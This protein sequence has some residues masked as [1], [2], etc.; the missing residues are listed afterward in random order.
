MTATRS[1][2]FVWLFLAAIT[3]ASWWLAP[4]HA[5]GAAQPSVPITVTVVLLGFVKGRM[6]LRYFMEVRS[7]PRWL[8]LATDGWLTA[9]WAAVLAIYLW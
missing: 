6:I 4:G 9:L 5:A 7:A 3:V 1:I 8:R 2:T